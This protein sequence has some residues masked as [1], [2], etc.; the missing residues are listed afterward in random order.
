MKN[1]TF[2]VA[3]VE[4][5]AT[6]D[7]ITK[8]ARLVGNDIDALGN[9]HKLLLSLEGVRPG[10]EVE[11]AM[12]LPLPRL[13]FLHHY[14]RPNQGDNL[15]GPYHYFNFGNH[16]KMSWDI[17]V[18][19]GSPKEFRIGDSIVIG[20]GIYFH[21]N[22]PRLATLI[23]NAKRSVAWGL[24]L[25]ERLDNSDFVRSF[26]LF[27]TRER[28]SALID[29]KSVFYVPCASCMN[30]VFDHI[31]R[32]S[33][34][35]ETPVVFHFN[36]GFNDKEIR[37]RLSVATPTT[38]TISSFVE[39][40]RNLKSAECIVTNSYHGAYW[41]SLLAKKVVCIPTEVPKWAGLHPNVILIHSADELEG[42][43]NNTSPVPHD[44][45]LECRL[46]NSDFF[47]RV[48]KML[49][50]DKEAL[51]ATKCENG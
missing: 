19:K 45:R 38:S 51:N 32:Q 46:V 7:G 30:P 17:E 3:S 27:G 50:S 16:L 12:K 40:I 6:E 36:G 43:I 24:G 31:D 23:K 34:K 15:S 20:G 28:Q 8:Y 22:K 4:T 44:Y 10:D 35:G 37:Q 5:I 42:A 26:D 14:D 49:K 25:D 39:I 13:H 21:R 47:D 29:N 18:V 11:F 33:K 41:G 9:P 48:Q 2:R 1:L